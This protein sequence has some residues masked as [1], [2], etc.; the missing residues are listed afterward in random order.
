MQSSRYSLIDKANEFVE[1]IFHSQGSDVFVYHNIGHTKRVVNSAKQIA[2]HYSLKDEDYIVLLI[3]AWF[4]DV[5][6]FDDAKHHE[7]QGAVLAEQFLQSQKAD[8]LFIEKVKNCIMATRMPQRPNNLV[9]EI[10]CDA[11]LF[12]LGSEEFFDNNKLMRKEF[13]LRCDSTMDKDRWRTKSIELLTNHRYHTEYA[14]L[15]LERGKERNLEKLKSKQKEQTPETPSKPVDTDNEKK[16]NKSDRPDRGIETMFRITSNNHQR[17]SDMADSKAQILITVNS[18]ILSVLISVLLRKI[19]ES[20]N[21]TI[22]VILL[23]SVNL[24]AIVFSILAAR[25]QVTHGIFTKR[26][27]SDKKVNLLFFGNFYK[28]SLEDYTSG[29]FQLMDDREYLYRS[30]IKDVY[31]QGV[32]LGRKYKLLRAAYNVFMFGIVISV[33]AFLIASFSVTS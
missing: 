30:L 1:P 7:K 23:L 16:K 28:M 14:K 17:L 2:E 26:D 4:H 3:A 20:P 10:L 8:L 5:G 32:V 11:D 15:L 27:V 31:S 22:P 25:P 19:E 13:Q 24:V 9:E 12:H 29:V 18:I 33:I 6:Y 21:L